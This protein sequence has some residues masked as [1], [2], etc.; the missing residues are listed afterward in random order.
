MDLRSPESL[1]VFVLDKL[2]DV[3]LKLV[4]RTTCLPGDRL[5]KQGDVE[6]PP[7]YGRAFMAVQLSADAPRELREVRVKSTS[8]DKRINYITH[9]LLE[10]KLRQGSRSDYRQ[11]ALRKTDRS[12]LDLRRKPFSLTDWNIKWLK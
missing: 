5:S 1:Y 2:C 11:I 7:V 9:N 4:K 3:I 6:I 8:I 12:T 10:F